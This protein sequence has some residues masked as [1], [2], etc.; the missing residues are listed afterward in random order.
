MGPVRSDGLG[1]HGSSGVVRG[2]RNPGVGLANELNVGHE[3]K[4]EEPG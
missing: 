3:N 2:S 1:Q 4:A